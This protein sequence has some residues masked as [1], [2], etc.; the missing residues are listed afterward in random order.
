MD[1]CRTR[2]Q[3]GRYFSRRDCSD[4]SI[5]TD[6]STVLKCNV[7]SSAGHR[8]G[9]PHGRCGKLDCSLRTSVGC[10]ECSQNASFATLP[11][12]VGIGRVDDV[13]RSGQEKRIAG[14]SQGRSA[15]TDGLIPNQVRNSAFPE[16]STFFPRRSIRRTRRH[17]PFQ[18]TSASLSRWQHRV[19][20]PVPWPRA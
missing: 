20:I 18:R 16:P 8:Y 6:Q 7:D 12:A 11:R 15:N 4:S 5:D 14:P 3:T 9:V 10:C 2:C 17:T 13:R 19:P 1:R